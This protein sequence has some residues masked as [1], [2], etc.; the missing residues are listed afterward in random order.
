MELSKEQ[1]LRSASQFI[2]S[3]EN[4]GKN[5]VCLLLEVAA[6]VGEKVTFQSAE[7]HG[8][9][10]NKMFTCEVKFGS[11][12]SPCKAIGMNKK[13]AKLSA[14]EQALEMLKADESSSASSSELNSRR[15][16]ASAVAVRKLVERVSPFD[17]QELSKI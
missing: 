4:H 13:M 15:Q 17:K 8:L 10:L 3:A 2:C 12:L 7:E 5:A 1:K 11:L 9:S 6:H 16:Q 14:A